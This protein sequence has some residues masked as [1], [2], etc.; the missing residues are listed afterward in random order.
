MTATV[1]VFRPV[2]SRTGYWER[3]GLPGRGPRLFVALE[4]GFVYKVY[5]ALA[6]QTGIEKQL[7]A[8]SLSISPATL[9]RR[10]KTGHFTSAESDRLYRFAEIFKAA[11]DLFEGDE[12]SA[13]AWL[14]KPSKGL[15]DKSPLQ[16]M[17]T[18]TEAE[19]VDELIGRLEHGAIV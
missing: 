4:Q 5:D 2:K 9:A 3:L 15:G 19:A 12:G 10:A 16:M 1:R 14:V 13:K 6:K 8:E 18:A 17:R 7:L 11:I